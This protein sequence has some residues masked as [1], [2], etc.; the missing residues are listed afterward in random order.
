MKSISF[1]QGE[2]EFLCKTDEKL[3]DTRLVDQLKLMMACKGQGLCAT[4]HVVVAPGYE[5]GLTPIS[6][7]EEKALERLSSR[8]AGSRL[9]CQARVIADIKVQIPKG[10]YIESMKQMEGLLGKR[11]SSNMLDPETGAV[12]VQEGQ[13]ISRFILKKLET[14][15]L[16]PWELG[17]KLRS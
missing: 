8:C 16:K 6:E 14:A 4:C 1:E 17:R 11:A 7:R 3:S 15:N 12:L 13:I 9:A 10:V 2:G 5:A